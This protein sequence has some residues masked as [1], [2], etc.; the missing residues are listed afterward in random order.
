MDMNE[1]VKIFI[2]Q[3]KDRSNDFCTTLVDEEYK[4]LIKL[5]DKL[6]GGI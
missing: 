6:T 4:R 1:D 3:L 5:I 2:K